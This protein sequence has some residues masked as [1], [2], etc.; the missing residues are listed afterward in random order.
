MQSVVMLAILRLKL[1]LSY[2]FSQ[3]SSTLRVY[4]EGIFSSSRTHQRENPL[5]NC[6]RPQQN[7]FKV[8]LQRCLTLSGSKKNILAPAAPSTDTLLFLFDCCL[9]LNSFVCRQT[10][11][12]SLLCGHNRRITKKTLFVS[13]PCR[14]CTNKTI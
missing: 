9:G 13:S 10:L 2:H 5:L 12:C 1:C 14:E 3:H 7:R 4:L 11:F 8:L 6:P